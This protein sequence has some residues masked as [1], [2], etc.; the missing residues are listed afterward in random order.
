[1]SQRVNLK[2]LALM[3]DISGMTIIFT[4]FQR[5][6]ERIQSRHC[7]DLLFI[8]MSGLFKIYWRNNK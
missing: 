7:Q 1:M 2:W 4:V 3:S 8:L 6:V 5:D